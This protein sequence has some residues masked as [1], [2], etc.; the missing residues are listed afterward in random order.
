MSEL[1]KLLKAYGIVSPVT[2]V[3]TVENGIHAESAINFILI[4]NSVDQVVLIV[5]V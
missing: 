2:N 4:L 1:R 3:Y 5:C